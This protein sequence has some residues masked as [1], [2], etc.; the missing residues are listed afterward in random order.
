MRFVQ[1]FEVH[2]YDP[3]ATNLKVQWVTTSQLEL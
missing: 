3:K 1:V 2:T